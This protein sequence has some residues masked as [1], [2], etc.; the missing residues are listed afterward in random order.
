MAELTVPDPERV[1]ALLIGIEHYP[2]MQGGELAGA[3]ADAMRLARWL[4]GRGVPAGNIRLLL[5]PLAASWSG[6]NTQARELGVTIEPVISRDQILDKLAPSPTV[7]EGDVLYVYWGG[8]GELDRGDRRLLLCPDASDADRRYLDLMDL[9]DY[10][11]RPD[12]ARCRR[13]VFLVDACAT[14]VQAG[15]T[16]RAVAA[17]PPGNRVPVEQF[18]L[19][20]AASGQAATH[21]GAARTGA[22]STAVMDWLEE[23][24]PGLGADLD[25]LVAHVKEHFAGHRLGSRQLQTPVTLVIQPFGGDV[26][27][28]QHSA[29]SSPP[30]REPS[31]PAAKP[32][33]PGGG[34]TGRAGL[35]A[36]GGGAL[37]LVAMVA[38]VAMFLS[39]QDDSD[40]PDQA[41]ASGAPAVAAGASAPG[42]GSPSHAVSGAVPSSPAPSGAST[43]RAQPAGATPVRDPESCAAALPADAPN[44]T[45]KACVVT[46]GT[47]VSM[48]AYVSAPTPTKVTVYAWLSLKEGNKYLYPI[49]APKSW[50]VTVGPDPIQLTERVAK[51]LTP[52]VD[53]EVHVSTKL[54]TSNQPNAQNNPNVTGHGQWFTY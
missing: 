50:N 29:G 35:W 8:H 27:I 40:Q 4:R 52:G 5:A 7:P 45:E 34:R 13:Q 41:A 51:S 14:F 32:S 15:R 36:A 11:T 46:E 24:S 26:E 23:R 3:A 47:R 20:A 37:A 21:R 9:R 31:A 33:P 16:G 30:D 17:L 25:A 49:G 54:P 38:I 2:R 1:H 48:R 39:R 22:F 43:P 42:S 28:W 12:V 19:L 18:M 44:V 53:Y 6:L 10:L